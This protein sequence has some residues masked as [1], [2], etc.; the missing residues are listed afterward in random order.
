MK[1]KNVGEFRRWFNEKIQHNLSF[2]YDVNY[3]GCIHKKDEEYI[4]GF[5]N[6]YHGAKEDIGGFLNS[7]LKIAEDGQAIYEF[8]QNA[9][10]ANSSLFYMFYNEKYFLAVNNGSPFTISGLKS[11]L[12]VA[13][14]DK[15]DAGKIGRF[16]IGFKLVHRLVGKG[17]GMQ[18]LTKEYKGP[19]LFSWSKKEDLISLMNNEK[20]EFDDNIFDDSK[21][22]LLFKFI[23]TNFPAAPGEKVKNLEYEDSILFP[24]SEYNEMSEFVRQSL[25]KYVEINDF[26]SG[27]IVFI[28]LGEGKKKLLDVD[29][30][31]NFK[32]GVEYSLN[33]IKGLSDVRVNDKL[34]SKNELIME[35]S[36]IE[37]GT[38]AFNEINPEYKESNIN[39]SVGYNCI[40]FNSEKPFDSVEKLK[41][42][43]SFYK[44]FP[45][46]DETHRSALFLHCDSFSNEANRRK[47]HEDTINR[48]LF[49]HIT[50]F[51]KSKLLEY[52]DT[53]RERFLQFYANILMCDFAHS[54]SEW[55]NEDLFNPIFTYAR[56]I[57]PTET[58]F[59]NNSSLVK[60]KR[61]KCTIPLS[62]ISENNYS[63]FHWNEK[64]RTLVNQAKDSKKL[65]LELWD[66]LDI[67]RKADIEKLNNWIELCNEE[68]YTQFLNELE[69]CLTLKEVSSELKK[70]IERVKLFKFS[71]GKFY[72]YNDVIKYITVHISYNSTT[73]ERRYDSIIYKTNKTSSIEG[74]LLKLG[75]I[76]SIININNF[77]NIKEKLFILPSDK[78]LFSI[79]EQ[80]VEG[81][82]LTKEEKRNLIVN[83]TSKDENKKFTDV[84]ETTIKK[85]RLCRN[86]KG[87]Y[88]SLEELITRYN[89]LPVWLSP[90]Q[91]NESDY[92]D[93][94]TPYLIS[95]K[96][97]YS[98]IIRQKWDELKLNADESFYK[99]IKY[100]YSLDKEAKDLSDKNFLCIADGQFVEPDKVFYNKEMRNEDLNYIDLRSALEKAFGL[101]TAEK[102]LLPFLE[103]NPFIVHQ[104]KLMDYNP[105]S[106]MLTKEEVSS[107]LKFC[108]DSEVD[109]K[110]FEK[111]VILKSDEDTFS[112]RLKTND[113]Y[114]VSVYG[115]SDA[116]K[117]F[118]KEHCPAMIP[119]PSEF[120]VYKD[121]WGIVKN[122]E[123]YINIL[124]SISYDLEEYADILIGI[125]SD[126]D[127]KYE[128]I[129]NLSTIKIN[130]DFDLSKDAWEY[131]II[132]FASR[133]LLEKGIS[134]LSS[135]R[136]KI[137]VVSNDGLSLKWD[138]IPTST[139][140][141]IMLE[142]L[143]KELLLSEILPNENKNTQY[144][145]TLIEKFVTLGLN[146]DSLD[147]LFGVESE[148]DLEYILDV[149]LS[150]Y[151]TLENTQ[152]VAYVC[153]RCD[154][155]KR[156]RF[157]IKLSDSSTYEFNR[158]WYI[159]N[160][161]FINESHITQGY[162]DLAEYIK[163]PFDTDDVLVGP[164]IK[165]K[166]FIC[167]GLKLNLSDSELI[168]LLNYIRDTFTLEKITSV[169]WSQINL[170][171]KEWIYPLDYAIDSEKMPKCILDW[172]EESSKNKSVLVA[173]GVSSE[174]SPIVK[175]RKYFKGDSQ[176]F[177][178][179]WLYAIFERYY[180]ENTLQW[181][182]D[183]NW[184][185]E[186][187]DIYQNINSLVDRINELRQSS[188]PIYRNKEYDFEII[189]AKSEEY[190][191]KIY[192]KWKAKTGFSIFLY[193]GLLPAY[194]K[195]DEYLKQEPF[196]SFA[197]DDVCNNNTTIYIN[198]NSDIQSVLHKFALENNVDFT[199]EFVYELFEQSI[200][201]LED[202]ISKLKEQLHNVCKQFEVSAGEIDYTNNNY[203]DA[204]QKKRNIRTGFKG[205]ILVFEL[206]KNMGYKPQCLSISDI[207][208]CEEKIEINGITYYCTSNY[209][210]YDILFENKKGV[211]VYVEVKATTGSKEN[212]S[213]M[214]IS[215]NELTKLE[216]CSSDGS[217]YY[218]ARVFGIDSDNPSIYF[219]KGDIIESE[220]DVKE[221]LFE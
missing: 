50:D 8:M 56:T 1:I 63:W 23:L 3:V 187:K 87:E 58:G 215:Y 147:K 130:I 166:E 128:L 25:Y 99:D 199:S 61:G 157:K 204:I 12:N 20:I 195:L 173:M 211:K 107:I 146:K 52:S 155:N 214:P 10:D 38:N 149:L 132:A 115:K 16:G 15:S 34:I 139:S 167:P 217:L 154:I 216:E 95:T 162:S 36:F 86:N 78:S 22:S 210:N 151:Q 184:K 55:L 47:L 31:K 110:F 84:G 176:L 18:E 28:K 53:D 57:V 76:I 186:S 45:L 126:D 101:N 13:Q 109:I 168:D 129:K 67:I 213:N 77:P 174:D 122:N 181:L 212:Q 60:I 100:Y 169:D 103:V 207:D 75:F 209:D 175:I 135:F 133:F 138:E 190:T 221:I 112:I 141:V 218:I 193:D 185:A 196:Y 182:A 125:L 83:I 144:V 105:S 205:E 93:E 161:S 119:L 114:Q 35:N 27:S 120:S 72:S 90:F 197:E 194:I 69:S 19:V 179:E 171:V 148:P 26:S 29:Y 85:L 98:K 152:Q 11:I 4:K 160:Y 102:F 6:V 92:F 14:S 150:S 145:N 111:F 177:K 71:D 140:N 189:C 202:T 206:L 41:L 42:S 183:L 164:Y 32:V 49:P 137:R 46:G 170:N 172:L 79:I 118:I 219:F 43:P 188:S 64:L 5:F 191:N 73:Y 44:Y 62:V 158:Q 9:A 117:K 108:I 54:N 123:L 106:N 37:K 21:S 74:E 131:K 220:K 7:S 39:F 40:D 143:K 82:N 96:D 66:L 113:Y 178:N 163:L 59:E 142:G 192:E 165:D 208:N 30:E 134:E 81:N 201:E 97:I 33:T 70:K 153:L 94:L 17:D 136:S 156:K 180:L 2:G 121:S 124:Q 127:S 104:K 48:N 89:N 91:I 65:G 200:K 198:R 203:V 24:E 51:I 68:T 116:L 159:K 88:K 80:K